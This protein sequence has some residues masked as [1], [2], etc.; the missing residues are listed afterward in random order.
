MARFAASTEGEEELTVSLYPNPVID[1]LTV[2]VARAH[3][4]KATSISDAT[5]KV[6]FFDQHELVE[7]QQLVEQLLVEQLQVSGRL[8]LQV[9]VSPLP[10]GL[11]LLQLQFEH[12]EQVL[13][14]VK[15]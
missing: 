2:L 9:D 7:K 11:Y 8:Q 5:G 1:K 4:I 14:F 10:P 15:Q 13:K 6:Q 12:G 3:Q